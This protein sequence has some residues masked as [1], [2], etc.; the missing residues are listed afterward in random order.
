MHIFGS[1]N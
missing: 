1:N